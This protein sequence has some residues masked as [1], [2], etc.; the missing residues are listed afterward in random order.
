MDTNFIILTPEN[1][2]L[3]RQLLTL[4]QGGNNYQ[5]NELHVQVFADGAEITGVCRNEYGT[6]WSNDDTTFVPFVE[7]PNFAARKLLGL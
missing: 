3:F 7:M 6:P 1:G 2:K 4:P 5:I